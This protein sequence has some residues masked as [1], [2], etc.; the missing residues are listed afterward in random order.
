[1]KGTLGFIGAGNMGG[2]LIRGIVSK[3]LCNPKE[4]FVYDVSTERMK[5]LER[6]TGI[7]IASS[8]EELAKKVDTVLLAVKPNNVMEVLAELGELLKARLL[9]SIAA[10]VR[11]QQYLDVLGEDARVVRV[12]PNTPALVLKGTSAI[13]PS[14]ACSADD[15][16]LAKHIFDAVGLCL[17]VEERLMDAVTGLSG[18]GPAFCFMFIEAM[19]DGGVRAGLPRDIALKLAASTLAGSAELVLR[20]GKHPGELKDMVASPAGTTIEGIS[21]LEGLGLRS[22]V[23]EAVFAAFKKS[24]S[25]QPT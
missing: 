18:S 13:S 4:I 6:D 7:N 21:V 17:E 2:A 23:M 9:M 20:T 16:A 1:M 25:I 12:M 11:L 15:I 22:A 8:G 19:A 5:G 10:G 3:G 14:R 24:A